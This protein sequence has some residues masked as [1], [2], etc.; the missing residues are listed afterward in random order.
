MQDKDKPN[1]IPAEALAEK[2]SAY[3]QNTRR[4]VQRICSTKLLPSEYTDAII[5]DVQDMVHACY[6]ELHPTTEQLRHI[7]E[8]IPQRRWDATENIPLCLLAEYYAKIVQILN[9]DNPP[10]LSDDFIAS[11]VVL[12][13]AKRD[14]DTPPRI[15]CDEDAV[16]SA[17]Q[18][19][20]Y[21]YAVL[22]VAEMCNATEAELRTIEPYGVDVEE[23]K[24]TR[25]IRQGLKMAAQRRYQ[26]EQAQKKYGRKK[27]TEEPKAPAAEAELFNTSSSDV[28]QTDKPTAKQS[29]LPAVLGDTERTILQYQNVAYMIGNGAKTANIV[30][31]GQTSEMRPIWKGIEEQ[32]TRAAELMN[33]ARATDEDRKRAADMIA[34]TYAAK[35]VLEGLQIIPQTPDCLPLSA[36]TEWITYDFTPH[37]YTRILTGQDKPNS[38]QMLSVLKATAWLTTQRMQVVEVAE[39]KK[40]VYDD[41]GKAELNEEGKPKY[42]KVQTKIVTNFQPVAVTFRSEYEDN[43]LIEEATRIRLSINPLLRDGR[44][45]KDRTAD[46]YI[47]AQAQYMKARQFYD[48]VTEEERIFRNVVISRPHMDEY[49]LLY[50]VFSYDKKQAEANQRAAAA[51]AVAKEMER[52]TTATDEEKQQARA[53]ADAAKKYAHNCITIHMGRDV[54]RLLGMF[55]KAY[56]NGLLTWYNNPHGGANTR[57]KKYGRGYVWEWGRGEE[58]GKKKRRG[59]PKAAEE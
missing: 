18:Q 5:A 34:T 36:S 49:A 3:I 11:V 32:R 19:L 17:T 55:K 20:Y 43:V 10:P 50:D 2:I 8:A 47:K 25:V 30:P 27:P 6:T 38:E 12:E 7:T 39:K 41:D 57:T 29:T 44:S 53:N 51:E 21:T 33:D 35:Q 28:Q 15:L 9:G 37:E 31:Y 48:F 13:V 1:P 42:R 56:D 52:N 59:R 40:R 14:T 22:S 4:K 23:D 26:R 58:D 54:E 45:T 16:L 46:G 24:R